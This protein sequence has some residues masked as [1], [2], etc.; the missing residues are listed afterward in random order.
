[1]NRRPM[2]SPS[3]RNDAKLY[4]PPGVGYAFDAAAPTVRMRERRA[5]K[6]AAASW[7]SMSNWQRKKVANAA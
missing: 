7:W 1:M 2:P 3:G 6:L 4:L 5:A